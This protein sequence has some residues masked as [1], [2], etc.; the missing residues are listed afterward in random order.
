MYPNWLVVEY[1][2]IFLTSNWKVAT[3]L[4]NKAVIVPNIHNKVNILFENSKNIDDLIIK[5]TPAVH[6]CCYKIK[7]IL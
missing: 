2:I 3:I 4:P 1:A 5:N 7:L 6:F